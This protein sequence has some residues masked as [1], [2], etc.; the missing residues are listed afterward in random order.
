MERRCSASLPWPGE[1]PSRA[2]SLPLLVRVQL[3][4]LPEEPRGWSRAGSREEMQW[5]REREEGEEWVRRRREEVVV[6]RSQGGR[7]RPCSRCTLSGSHHCT[8]QLTLTT[9]VLLHCTVFP[10]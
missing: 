4:E 9:L 6:R 1:A 5:L 7:G 10:S 3:R 8:G 2:P